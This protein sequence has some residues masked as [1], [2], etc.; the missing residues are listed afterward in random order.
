MYKMVAVALSA[1]L[2]AGVAHAGDI[3]GA[4]ATFP[5][6]V[7]AKW[8]EGYRAQTGI[9][10]NYQ[11]IGS[12]GGIKQILA[13]TVAFGATD[14][15]MSDEDLMKN[16]LFQF[17][18]VMGGILPVVNLPGVQPGTMKLDADVLADIFLGKITKWTDPKIVALNPGLKIPNWP[19]TVVHRSDGSGTT[20]VWTSYLALKNAE[21]KSKV[22]ANTD[23]KWPVGQG[24]KGNDG[25]AAVVKQTPGAIGYV[26]Y[27]FA[28]ANKLTHTQLKDHDG[29]FIQPD[30]ETFQTAAAKA[31]FKAPGYS[32][33]LLDQAGN[34]WP[35]TSPGARAGGRREGARGTCPPRGR[36]GGSGGSGPSS[37]CGATPPRTRRATRSG[38]T[39]TSQNS[40]GSWARRSAGTG[41]CASWATRCPT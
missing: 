7:Y 23:V 18:A 20:Y 38:P 11:A 8:A 33:S 12:G 5:A 30:F 25:V 2:L 24:G 15:P 32:T 27:V 21:W 10:L 35:V 39:G 31:V 26:E 16:G 1:T 37:R 14:K 29:Q 22:G 34:A 41:S 4:G 9:G 17:P 13:K 36:G 19:V 28:H 3:S 6:P 40:G